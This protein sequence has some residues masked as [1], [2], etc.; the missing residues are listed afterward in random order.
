MILCAILKN[1]DFLYFFLQNFKQMSKSD[2]S[3]TNGRRKRDFRVENSQNEVGEID[4]RCTGTNFI[5]FFDFFQFTT[6]T[7][8]P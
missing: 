7:E 5:T 3:D 1:Y 8:T 2:V 6:T 4:F